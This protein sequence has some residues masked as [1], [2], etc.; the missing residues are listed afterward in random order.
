M[1]TEK[2]VFTAK[3]LAKGCRGFIVCL[4]DGDGAVIGKKETDKKGRADFEIPCSGE[5]SVGAYAIGKSPYGIRS[6]VHLCSEEDCS[7]YFVFSAAV[8]AKVKTEF[9]VTDENYSGLPINQGEIN[10]WRK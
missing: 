5:Y 3:C 7:K 6:W 9:R 1:S 2:G 4:Y 8:P 10:L